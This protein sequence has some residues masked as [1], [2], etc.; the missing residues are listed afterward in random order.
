MNGTCC[1]G[2]SRAP[3]CSPT[4]TGMLKIA[5]FGLATFFDAARPQP[6]TSRVVTL[7]Y[8]PPE[9][10][11]GATEYGV[12]V[13]L[14]S[15]GCMPASSPSFSP[16]SPSCILAQPNQDRAAAQDLQ[17]VQVAVEIVLGEGEAAGRDAVQAA[18]AVPAEDRRDVQGLL[19]AGARPPRHAACHRAVRPGHRGTAPPPP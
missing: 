19:A 11:L 2:T 6:L 14:C 9:L 7:W 5:D 1:I 17:A 3:T 16:A 18:V 15:T 8:R 4:A 12:A 13:D 10:L